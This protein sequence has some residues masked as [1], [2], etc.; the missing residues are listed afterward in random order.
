[1]KHEICPI[2]FSMLVA[3]FLGS[4]VFFIPKPGLKQKIAL[5]SSVVF[6]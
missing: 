3:V 5:L 6:C 4:G 1:M 2:L